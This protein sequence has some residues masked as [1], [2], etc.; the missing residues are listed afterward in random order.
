MLPPEFRLSL[1]IDHDSLSAPATAAILVENPGA[2]AE[3]HYRGAAAI[4]RSLYLIGGPLSLLWH[5]HHLPAII[6]ES[7]YQMIAKHRLKLPLISQSCPLPSPSM[8]RHILP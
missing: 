2:E 3:I 4:L 1:G 8:K 5:L 7:S 6:T